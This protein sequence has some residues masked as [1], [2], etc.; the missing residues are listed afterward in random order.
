[1]SRENTTNSQLTGKALL[2]KLSKDIP[3]SPGVYKMLDSQSKILY[4]GK[5]KNLKNRIS[6]Y[7]L[8]NIHLRVN[9]MV[10][11][12][13][14]L[15]Y[16]IT[17]NETEALLLEANLIKQFQPRYNILL[18]D[19][20]TFPFF[21]I[22]LEDTYPRIS[23]FRSKNMAQTEGLFGPFA[24]AHDVSE[25]IKIFQTFFL[26]RTCTNSYFNNRTKPCILYQIK[27]CS[28]PCV[29]KISYE[30]YQENVKNL[31]DFLNGKRS[32][33]KDE[34][35][36]KMQQASKINNFEQAIIYRDR[37]NA[38]NTILSKQNIVLK[39]KISNDY[40]FMQSIGNKFYVSIMIIRLGKNY[41]T[42]NYSINSELDNTPEQVLISFV[43]QYYQN[44]NLPEGLICN[45]KLT[46]ENTKLLQAALKKLNNNKNVKLHF[47]QVKKDKELLETVKNNNNTYLEN[48]ENTI[49][50][51]ASYFRELQDLFKINEEIT[52]I[53]IYDNSHLYGTLPLGV[54][55][56]ALPSGF[57]K[58]SYKIFN[59]K[60]EQVKKQDDYAILNEVLTRRFKKLTLENTPQLV[61]I[62]GGK[63]QLN[64][65]KKVLQELSIT[66]IT[67]VG[68]AKGVNRNA[69]E[70][71]LYLEDGSE[72]SL[73]KFSPLLHFIQRLRNEAHRFAIKTVR[74]KKLK[75]L[76]KS[77]LDTIP[78]IGKS[79]KRDLLNY[80][81]SIE[82]I[83]SA[84]LEELT[85]VPNINKTIAIKI[86]NWLH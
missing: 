64:I 71:T 34:L 13:Y 6:S 20:K 53:E 16:I 14:H 82:K 9:H 41:G 19:D 46:A 18:K 74:N 4:I 55:V 68:I 67:L 33:I 62:D 29:N 25:N 63:G 54:M 35:I 42:T 28:A 66:N 43:S 78:G 7:I 79:R 80:F 30:N 26:L 70:E 22:S 50:K 58:S 12:I 65:A 36:N 2:N 56:C 31:I 10:K 69:G 72:I 5:A 15:E 75:N 77:E 24:S 84:S 47:P 81:T 76:T 27:R 40:I 86:Y 52:R 48:I 85:K 83:K 3:T 1:M 44:R 11:Q 51:W 59:L 23:K 38:L 45:I 61:F 73:D 32:T 57:A 37:I 17:N 8:P 39:E 49:N 21:K 60:N